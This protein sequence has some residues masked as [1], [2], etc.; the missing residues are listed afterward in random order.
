MSFHEVL[1]Q[2]TVSIPKAGVA[3]TL[4]ARTAVMGNILDHIFTFKL[5]SGLIGIIHYINSQAKF[6]KDF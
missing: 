3:T 2:Q 4:N 5:H 6:G 1:E